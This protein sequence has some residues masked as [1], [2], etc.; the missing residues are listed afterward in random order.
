MHTLWSLRHALEIA[1]SQQE[2]FNKKIDEDF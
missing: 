2:T 1:N